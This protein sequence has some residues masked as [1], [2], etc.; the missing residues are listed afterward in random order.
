M[1]FGPWGNAVLEEIVF[2]MRASKQLKLSDKLQFPDTD[3]DELCNFLGGE[4]LEPLESMRRFQQTT[5]EF[6]I[7]RRYCREKD[8]KALWANYSGWGW[9]YLSENGPDNKPLY[10]VVRY[11]PAK[12]VV[13]IEEKRGHRWQRPFNLYLHDEESDAIAHLR[14]LLT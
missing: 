8:E 13:S 2:A 4:F 3:L 12:G 5:Y 1:C 6:D 11:H 7:F 10:C 14:G 9:K